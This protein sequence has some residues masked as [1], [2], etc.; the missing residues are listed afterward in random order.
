MD[1]QDVLAWGVM[2]YLN[3]PDAARLRRASHLCSKM[4]T[5]YRHVVPRWC[6]PAHHVHLARMQHGQLPCAPDYELARR[7]RNVVME[8]HNGDVLC[9]CVDMLS[10]PLRVTPSNTVHHMYLGVRPANTHC[11][12]PAGR[13]GVAIATP[14][15]VRV[16]RA[17]MTWEPVVPQMMTTHIASHAGTRWVYGCTRDG[18]YRFDCV[19]MQATRCFRFPGLSFAVATAT[20][21]LVVP[22]RRPSIVYTLKHDAIDDPPTVMDMPGPIVDMH[23]LTDNRVLFVC[24]RHC[25]I[26]LSVFRPTRPRPMVWTVVQVRHYPM[27]CRWCVVVQLDTPASKRIK[28]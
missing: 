27:V 8:L 17:D 21:V 6:E 28:R 5:V 10:A 18:V 12:K 4:R 3:V 22:S 20:H 9:L 1:W 24:A 26:S 13:D 14:C 19:D 7:N 25:G 23:A 16:Y 11:I 2:Q 15:S